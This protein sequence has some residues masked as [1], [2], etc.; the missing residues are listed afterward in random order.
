M[1]WLEWVLAGCILLFVCSPIAAMLVLDWFKQPEDTER[2]DD[3]E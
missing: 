1:S 3:D 2:V